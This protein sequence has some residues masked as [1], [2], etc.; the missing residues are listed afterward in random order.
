MSSDLPSDSLRLSVV[1]ERVEVLTARVEELTRDLLA[2][3]LESTRG[4]ER[5]ERHYPTPVALRATAPSSSQDYEALARTIPPVSEEALRLCSLLSGGSLSARARAE[6]AWES[7]WWARFVLEGSI[8]TPRPS[9]PIDVQNS[10]Y[11]VLR[12]EGYSTPL[13]VQKASHYRHIVG[14][15]A[16]GTISHGF[17][18][19]AE[20]KVYCLAAGVQW[21]SSPY[22]LPPLST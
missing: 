17:P 9:K 21:P 12:A 22:Q 3:R 5:G 13:W 14:N 18:S 6:R 1:E 16:R 15:F 8:A 10:L 11:V 2:L 19:Q 7:G 20:A 4:G